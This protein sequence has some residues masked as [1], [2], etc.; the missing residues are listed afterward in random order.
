VGNLRYLVNSAAGKYSEDGDGLWS[1]TIANGPN[2]CYGRNIR[3]HGDKDGFGM[4]WRKPR[5]ALQG[6]GKDRSVSQPVSIALY[7]TLA[8]APRPIHQ[9]APV[10]RRRIVKNDCNPHLAR[11]QQPQHGDE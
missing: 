2:C 9:T 4:I 5:R 7:Q 6:N 8:V 10:V 1:V 11:P 3:P